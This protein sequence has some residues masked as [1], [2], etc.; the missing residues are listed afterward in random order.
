MWPDIN[1]QTTHT[2]N[3]LHVIKIF[4]LLTSSICSFYWYSIRKPN[5]VLKNSNKKIKILFQNLNSYQLVHFY[6]LQMLTYITIIL[7][8]RIIES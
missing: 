3:F 4:L 7:I 5:I 6:I 2:E 8:N 1:S